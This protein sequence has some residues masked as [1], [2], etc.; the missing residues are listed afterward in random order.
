MY[1]ICDIC[2]CQIGAVSNSGRG[3]ES[4][5]IYTS[6]QPH[7]IVKIPSEVNFFNPFGTKRPLKILVHKIL[8]QK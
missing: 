7:I 1:D 4:W 6:N 5:G 3:L 2:V 8:Q